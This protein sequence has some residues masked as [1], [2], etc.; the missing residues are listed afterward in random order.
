MLGALFLLPVILYIA[1]SL[2][3]SANKDALLKKAGT[4]IGTV[5]GGSVSIADLSVSLFNN[6]PYLSIELKKVDVR[7]SLFARHGH[8]FL[9]AEKLFLR[10]SPIKLLMARLS[11]NKLEIDS[12]HLHLF[13]DSSGYSNA[14]LLKGSNKSAAKETDAATANILD[15]ISLNNF[16][17]IIEDVSKAKLFDLYI[18]NL[19]ATTKRVAGTLEIAVSESIR[20]KTLA[21]NQNIGSYLTNHLLAGEYTLQ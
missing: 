6:F 9:Y 4:Q 16:A 19:Q 21:F 15:K 3:V 5:I 17:V 8:S 12:G 11:I 13:T 20:V 7:D 2:Y 1:L 14:Y 10:V 18:A